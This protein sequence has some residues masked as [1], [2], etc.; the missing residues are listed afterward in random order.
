MHICDKTFFHRT[1]TKVYITVSKNI[2]LVF[3]ILISFDAV[4]TE[5]SI[6]LD[7][8]QPICLPKS[9]FPRSLTNDRLLAP[10]WGEVF[11]K[12]IGVNATYNP[13][14]ELMYLNAIKLDLE[15]CNKVYTEPLK[16]NDICVGYPKGGR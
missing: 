8:V 5:L 15:E 16:E 1:G 4:Y 2:L 3:Q 14:D 12:F 13:S 7:F 10:G 9:P 11:P 6:F